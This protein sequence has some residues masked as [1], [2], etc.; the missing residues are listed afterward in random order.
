MVGE[1][2]KILFVNELP[3]D[4]MAMADCVR[5]LLLGYPVERIAWWYCRESSVRGPADLRAGSLHRWPLPARLLPLRRLRSL[6][7]ALLERIWTPLAARHLWRTVAEVKPDLIWV[8]LYGWPILVARNAFRRQPRYESPPRGQE[9]PRSGP[10]LHVSL[11]DFPDHGEGQRILGPAR[12]QRM[13]EAI[14]QLVRQADSC[15]GISRAVLEEIRSQTGRTDAV[16]VHS[17]FEP[18]HLKDLEAAAGASTDEILRLAYVGSIISEDSFLKMLAALDRARAKLP[19]RVVLEFFGARGYRNRS[20]FNPEWM[21]EHGVFSDRGLVESLQRCSW[22]IVVMDLEG[23]DPRYSRFSFPN[24][25]GTCLSAGVPVL[26]LGHQRTSLAEVMRD[27][28]LGMFA[29][30]TEPGALENFLSESLRITQPRAVFREDILRCARTEF[31]AEQIRARLWR[32]WGV[33]GLK[34]NLLSG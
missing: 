10:R 20:W 1:F 9:S 27:H 15:D 32:T 29:D 3:P 22:G 4:S 18:R 28:R 23:T 8:L 33:T 26:G 24:K 2:P 31:N 16:H 11:W 25:I 34:Q 19:Q 6:K 14:F 12:A 30:A 21:V 7:G 5:Q 17:G 13:V